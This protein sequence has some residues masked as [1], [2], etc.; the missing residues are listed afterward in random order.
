MSRNPGS[1]A[2][3]RQTGESHGGRIIVTLKINPA[4]LFAIKTFGSGIG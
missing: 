2:P 4:P 3:R 1:I